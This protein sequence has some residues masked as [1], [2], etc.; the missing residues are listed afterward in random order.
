LDPTTEYTKT[1]IIIVLAVG[2]CW[3]PVFTV[4]R[5][6]AV[7]R[8]KIH[9]YRVLRG[10]AVPAA[11]D[12]E[13]LM[14]LEEQRRRKA[15]TDPEPLKE[16]VQNS[17]KAPNP[18]IIPARVANFN[19]KLALETTSD[20][21]N[22]G[23]EPQSGRIPSDGVPSEKQPLDKASSAKVS[24]NKVASGK[25]PARKPPSGTSGSIQTKASGSG[26]GQS[27]G[28]GASKSQQTSNSCQSSRREPH[29]AVSPASAN[30]HRQANQGKT[31][32][33]RESRHH[34][35][36]PPKTANTSLSLV[37]LSRTRSG[38]QIG[39]SSSGVKAGRGS[40]NM[41]AEP[42]KLSLPRISEPL[43]LP[44]ETPTSADH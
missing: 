15:A 10:W 37:A 21:L 4:Y 3:L 41:G 28:T 23:G 33:A 35:E 1:I 36:R 38:F 14:M 8:R 7:I 13:L 20:S 6:W 34:K 25:M 44:L 22:S 31:R 42:H 30:F 32:H 39:E 27:G 17:E 16:E 29:L 24:S 12:V 9:V 19:A 40:S 26:S 2:L 18:M 43:L 5:L 11:D